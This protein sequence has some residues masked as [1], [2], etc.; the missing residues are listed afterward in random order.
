[1]LSVPFFPDY[2]LAQSSNSQFVCSRYIEP[3]KGEVLF[4]IQNKKD[5]TVLE[6]LVVGKASNTET[7]VRIMRNT[8]CPPAEYI[9]EL[10][11]AKA[12]K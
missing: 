8:P 3:N 9:K 1:L 10:E 12:K 4:D 11:E 7:L 2:A 5:N 6:G